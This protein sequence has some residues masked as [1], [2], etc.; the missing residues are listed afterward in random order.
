[1]AALA[2]FGYIVLLM[3]L[4]SVIMAISTFLSLAMGTLLPDLAKK[5]K[6]FQASLSLAGIG[7]W[8]GA[9]A[10]VASNGWAG[11]VTA[12]CFLAALLVPLA[13]FIQVQRHIRK[14]AKKASAPPS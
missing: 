9:Y 2:K 13:R 5:D 1:M 6:V 7:I 12:G 8:T 3:V 14:Y 11:L 10:I 4:A